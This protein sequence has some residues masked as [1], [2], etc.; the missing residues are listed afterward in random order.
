MHFLSRNQKCLLFLIITT[1][2][3]DIFFLKEIDGE[4]FLFLKNIFMFRLSNEVEQKYT[5]NTLISTFL[6]TM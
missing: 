6:L 4:L 2:H 1:V 3:K 5:H